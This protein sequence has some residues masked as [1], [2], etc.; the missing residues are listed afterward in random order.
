MRL[1]DDNIIAKILISASCGI[2]QLLITTII[3]CIPCKKKSHLTK[4][5]KFLFDWPV[6]S[7]RSKGHMVVKCNFVL[8][9]FLCVCVCVF[10]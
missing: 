5:T 9:M 4:F 3:N 8:Q 2:C 7:K 10:T 6:H 1:E